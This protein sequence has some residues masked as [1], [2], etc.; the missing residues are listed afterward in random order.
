MSPS[1]VPDRVPSAVTDPVPV[2]ILSGFLGAGKSTLLNE[3]LSD[4][5]F[6]DTAVIVNE[7]GDISIDHDLIRV[8]QREMM[9]TTTGCICCTAGSDARASLFELQE[10]M[11]REF[12]R[13]F[14]RVV[15]ETTGLADPAPLVNQLIPG[16]MPAVG[17]RDHVVARRFFLAGFVCAVDVT[18]VEQ[19]IEGHFECLK[20]VTFADVLVLTKSDLSDSPGRATETIEALLRDI[21]PSAT[22]VDRN[23]SSFDLAMV[24][25]PRSFVPSDRE[26][27]V[28]D[29]LALDRVLAGEQRDHVSGP[30]TGRH[31]TRIRTF[32]VVRDEP[33]SLAELELFLQLLRNAAGPK[34]LRL[35]GIV[36][37]EGRPDHPVVVHAVQHAIHPIRQL[38]AWPSPDRRTRLVLIGYGIDPTAVRRLFDT[39]GGSEKRAASGRTLALIAVLLVMLL[40]AALLRLT[41]NRHSM[42]RVSNRSAS[43]FVQRPPGPS[44][45]FAHLSHEFQKR[46]SARPGKERT[47]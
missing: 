32:S 7:F 22:I 1:P 47:S 37:V 29:W 6:A 8:G 16:G 44:M 17:L 31:D 45:S 38:D 2:I 21:N 41:V 26:A 25:T 36:S 39:F 42:S 12:G 40:G 23:A 14:S 13:A 18:S 30:A 43:L 11:A 9:V 10:A 33:V 35:K 15:I 24:F 27:D 3:L 19:T 5:A 28:E 20:Q 34:L 4:P 46:H